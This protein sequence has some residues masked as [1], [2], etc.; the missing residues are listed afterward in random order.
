[1]MARRGKGPR[2]PAG[3]CVHCNTMEGIWSGL[4]NDLDHF[5]SISQR[6][7]HFESHATSSCTIMDTC[8]G[9]RPS[10]Q[11]CGALSRPQAILCGGW[12][13]N[14]VVCC[15]RSATDERT[16]LQGHA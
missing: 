11:P 6:F 2:D 13:I 5:K 8:T 16:S 7:L 14:I 12:P 1:M 3:T 10:K 9:V 4:R 15:S